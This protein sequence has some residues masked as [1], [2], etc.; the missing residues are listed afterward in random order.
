MATA[1]PTDYVMTVY[2]TEK[3]ARAGLIDSGV[4]GEK[5]LR[6]EAATATITI[7]DFTELNSTDSVALVASDG[8]SYTFQNGS[9]S[10]VNGTWE[11]T[12]SNDATATN[13]M[14]VINTS[15]GPAGTR[16][17]ATVDGAVVTVT[18]A[19][20]GSSGNTTITLT[21]TNTAGMT[22]TDFTGGNGI[23]SH[24]NQNAGYDFWTHTKYWYRIESNE[25]V[26]EFYIDWDD[27]E[28]N[29]P[30]GKANYTT[31][32]LDTPSYVGIAS[33]IYTGNSTTNGAYFPKIR[34]KSVEGYW[35]KFYHNTDAQVQAEIGEIEVLQGHDTLLA[36]RND[37]YVIEADSTTERIPALYP[38]IK[39]P[40]AILKSDK[41]RIYAG[42]NN[43]W[44]LTG[45]GTDSGNDGNTCTLVASPDGAQADRDDVEVRVTYMTAGADD[46]LSAG[47]G[48]IKVTDMKINGAAQITYVTKVLKM[49]LLNHLEDSVSHEDSG[50]TN[51][52]LYPGEK[53][54]LVYGAHSTSTRQT[55]GEVSLGN[56]IITLDD[57]R[58]TITYDLTESFARTPEQSISNYYLDD[59]HAHANAGYDAG[60]LY[61]Q[62][63]SGTTDAVSDYLLDTNGI[64]ELSTGVTK[65][66]Y[67]FDINNNWVDSDYRWLSKQILARG[68]I[69]ISTPLADTTRNV[70]QLYSPLEHWLNEGH[71]TN[72]SDTV[73]SSVANKNWSSDLTSSGL[74]AF[75]STHDGSKKWI[76]LETDNRKAGNHTNYILQSG[77]EDNHKA[78]G[79][80]SS[81]SLTDTDNKAMLVCARD[82]K[83]TKLFFNTGARNG[84]GV[85]GKADKVLPGNLTTNTGGFTGKGHMYT[86]V[87]GFYTG[88][89]NDKNTALAWKPL[90]ML[91]TTKHPDYDN[92]TWYTDGYFEW[93]E[94]TDWASVDPDDI[95][96][97]FY[98]RGDYFTAGD[99][100]QTDDDNTSWAFSSHNQAGSAM[101]DILAATE[102]TVLTVASGNNK[103]KLNGG[104]IALNRAATSTWDIFWWNTGVD[105]APSAAEVASGTPGITDPASVNIL[106]VDVTGGGQTTDADFAT[107]L[108]A[109]LASS[110]G[111]AQY[112]TAS[113][114]Y[115]GTA[116]VVTISHASP[117]KATD[118]PADAGMYPNGGGITHTVN[119][120]TQGQT[121][122]NGGDYFETGDLWNATNKKY[123]L[124]FL[125]RTDAG[126][127]ANST[128]Y[129][130][131]TIEHIW[132]CSNSHSQIVELVDPMCVSLNSYAITQSIS[133]VHKG[134]YQK[135]ED[136]LGKTDIRKIGAMSGSIKFGGIDLNDTARAKF[137]EF[138]SKATPVYL[139]VTHTN[140]D[141][142]RFFGVITGMSQDH[143][144]GNVTPKFGLDMEV[145]HMLSM[146]S[147]GAILSD[148]YISLGG[149][150]DEPKYI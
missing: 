96:D 47:R 70:L 73:D 31:I 140:G 26:T 4:S 124:M 18:Q 90:K 45:N 130:Y 137:Y 78:F 110:S 76:D 86:Q 98:P 126:A 44:F 55:I 103:V 67:N 36:G 2:K 114:G 127:S 24:G 66:A 34:V 143:P 105:P 39:P 117:G 83:W 16:F 136:R 139:D 28:D 21:D 42:I 40:V 37:T 149:N 60:E 128:D 89:E 7:T 15:S 120:T 80:A 118:A 50:F 104:W 138:Q 79:D 88:Y 87:Q 49:E 25:P 109:L 23:V 8:N 19:V 107:A 10:S 92:T 57:P 71:T 32:K 51:T 141:K 135:V 116:A 102:I 56:P 123:G 119:V 74:I 121:A 38:S 27:G 17:T 1:I 95:P 30:Q 58:H 9:Q 150:I 112:Y 53:M 77:T 115:G 122:H 108:Q 144:T 64:L 145:S 129:E 97:K 33:H 29:N 125:I 131:T 106:A 133:Y 20:G 6:V 5:A 91:N 84:D 43:R 52:K 132:P 142:S 147:S 65:R 146:N 81:T 13:L 62:T 72:Y 148:G 69:K 61:Q 93:E 101:T 94:P 11:S 100:S 82:K 22:K 59:G 75:K 111:I 54:V 113:V 68:Q 46:S 48:D 63:G 3:A 85:R 12:T 99:A 134:K 35:S 41:K 14:N